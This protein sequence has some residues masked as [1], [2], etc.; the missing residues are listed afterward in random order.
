[1]QTLRRVP[2]TFFDAYFSGRYAQDVCDDGSIFVDRDGEHF[3]HVLEYMRDGVVSV[4]EEGAS[5]S[6]SL[7]RLLKRE[8]GFYCIELCVEQAVELEIAYAMDDVIEMGVKQTKIERYDASSG[9]WSRAA[10]MGTA[11]SDFGACM[12]LGKLYA[13][14]GRGDDNN[15][16]SSVENYT[17]LSGAWSADAPMP[18]ARSFHVAVAV[19]SNM[20]VLGGSDGGIATPSVLTFNSTQGT[21]RQITPMPEPRSALA[22]CAIGID[23]YVFGGNADR[24]D[25]AS[26]FKLDTETNEW[27]TLAPMPHICSFHSA[28]LLDGLI[29]VVGAGTRGREVLCFDPESDAWRTLAPT[30]TSRQYGASFVMGGSLYAA[31]GIHQSSGECYDV[32]SNTWTAVANML[33]GW[34]FLNVVIGSAG[35]TEEQDLFDSLVA[36]ASRA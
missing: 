11:R 13:I 23:I 16:L 4:A 29:Y 17:P 3:W 5:P 2:H 15:L 8:F 33:D 36:K 22:A 20:Y 1:V 10:N 27:S 21:W 30:S 32:A 18:T 34:C 9:Q 31:G 26:V 24:Q 35:P 25:H 6:V 19:G 12:L 28:N 7:L 14:G